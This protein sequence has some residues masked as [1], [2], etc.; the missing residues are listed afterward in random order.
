MS[1]FRLLTC[2]VVFSAGLL[3]LFAQGDRATLG[4]VVK[5]TTGAVIPNAAVSVKHTELL[6]N[7]VRTYVLPCNV[8]VAGS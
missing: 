7:G 2:V 5:D 1:T 3:P 6:A 4:G 8:V